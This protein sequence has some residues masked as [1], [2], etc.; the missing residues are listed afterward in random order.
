VH[1]HFFSVHAHFFS[2]HAHFSSV[3]A[4]FFS[5]HAQCPLAEA[6]VAE[7]VEATTGIISGHFD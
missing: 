3:H 4:H 6:P 7:P 1:A 2:V 5:A